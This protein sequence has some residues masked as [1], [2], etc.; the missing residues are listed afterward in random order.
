MGGALE[1]ERVEVGYGATR[2]LK[3]ISL[4]IAPGGWNNFHRTAPRQ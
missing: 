3:G 1:V 4:A 2:V